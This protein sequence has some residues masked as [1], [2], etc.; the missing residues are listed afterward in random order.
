METLKEYERMGNGM[1]LKADAEKKFLPAFQKE[2]RKLG[3]PGAE[4]FGVG[5][6][7]RGTNKNKQGEDGNFV[8][9]ID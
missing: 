8:F 5:A 3:I 1:A 9:R 6:Y 2:L 7:I 4:K